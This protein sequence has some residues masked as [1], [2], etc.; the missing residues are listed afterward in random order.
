MPQTTKDAK[1]TIVLD[2]ETFEYIHTDPEDSIVDAA[3]EEDIDVPFSCMAGVCSSC[4]ARLLKG[5][6]TMDETHSLTEEEIADKYILSCQSHPTS[7]EV[8]I[9]FDDL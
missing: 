3:L 8:H 9:S 6:V 7:D 4:R 1:I 5:S 2:G